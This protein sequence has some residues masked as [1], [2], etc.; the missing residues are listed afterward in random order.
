MRES[1]TLAPGAVTLGMEAAELGLVLGLVQLRRHGWD[2]SW[3][4]A[5]LGGTAPLALLAASPDSFVNNRPGITPHALL[6]KMSSAHLA[7]TF[8][9]ERA[10]LFGWRSAMVVSKVDICTMQNQVLRDALVVIM[11]C[12]VQGRA[13]VPVPAIHIS[14]CMQQELHHWKA[15]VSDS[16]MQRRP[17]VVSSCI[18]VQAKLKQHA[19]SV[20]IILLRSRVMQQPIPCMSSFPVCQHVQVHSPE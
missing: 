15:A 7:Q 8:T 5:R 2:L 13:T 9:E 16:L 20:H 1:A 12:F 17:T 14:S 19:R 18:C 10:G 11:R 6:L 3:L 4:V